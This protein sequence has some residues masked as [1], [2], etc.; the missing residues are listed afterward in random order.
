VQGLLRPN[1]DPV[2]EA[3]ADNCVAAQFRAAILY[4]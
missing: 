2:T 3:H 1:G 4:N